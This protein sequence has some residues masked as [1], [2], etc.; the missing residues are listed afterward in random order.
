MIVAQ[1]EAQGTLVAV[2]AVCL[3][4]DSLPRMRV[5]VHPLVCSDSSRSTFSRE[6]NTLSSELVAATNPY[7]QTDTVVADER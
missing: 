4:S 7:R 3:C 2:H 6:V 5:S 1:L